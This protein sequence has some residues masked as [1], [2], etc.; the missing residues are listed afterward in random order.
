MDGRVADDGTTCTVRLENEPGRVVS[1][2]KGDRCAVDAAETIG[3]GYQIQNRPGD[4]LAMG[5]FCQ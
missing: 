4:G 2:V 3:V 1:P 5:S